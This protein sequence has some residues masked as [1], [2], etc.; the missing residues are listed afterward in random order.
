MKYIVTSLGLAMLLLFAINASAQNGAY[1]SYYT[2]TVTPNSD[3]SAYVTP[4]AEVTG[5]DDVSDW[6]E[7]SYR[8]VCTVAPKIQLTGDA[9][10]VGGTRVALGRTVDQVRTGS[11][12]YVPAGGSTVGVDYSVEADVRCSGPP[13]PNYWQYP[14]LLDLYT[15]YPGIDINFWFLTGFSPFQSSPPSHS[16]YCPSA[17]S[18]PVGY[19]VAS[20]INFVDFADF[21]TDYIGS[22]VTLLKMIP[23][24]ENS[25][26]V[27]LGINYC[28]YETIAWCTPQTTPPRYDPEGVHLVPQAITNPPGSPAYYWTA[29]GL[30]Y[31]F[32]KNDPF[33]CYAITI[34]GIAGADNIPRSPCTKP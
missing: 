21:A 4:T 8:P 19:G 33:T 18:C 15:W 32:N 3:G 7:G 13:N 27:I 30:C 22:A 11:A 31:K 2:Y 24:T 29:H 34:A 1:S 26:R 28:D 5:I 12:V 14:S 25:C 23:G 16:Q 20:I 17:V 10:W 9:A 6:I